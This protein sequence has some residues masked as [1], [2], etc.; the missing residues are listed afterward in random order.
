MTI[1]T[2][3]EFIEKVGWE[4]ET[5]YNGLIRPAEDAEVDRYKGR[6]LLYK[7]VRIG[8]DKLGPGLVIWGSEPVRK[9]PARVVYPRLGDPSLLNES[10]PHQLFIRKPIPAPSSGAAFNFSG[11]FVLEESL[12]YWPGEPRTLDEHIKAFVENLD[13]SYSKMHLYMG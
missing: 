3:E 1:I 12:G 4:I 8:D 6:V 9:K 2:P 7:A 11:E 10:D 13:N 5:A